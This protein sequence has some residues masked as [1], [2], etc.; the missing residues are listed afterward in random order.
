M[1]RKHLNWTRKQKKK[2]KKKKKEKEKEKE[3]E[4]KKRNS[5][6]AQWCEGQPYLIRIRFVHGASPVST[7][8]ICDWNR[9]KQFR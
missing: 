8:M 7:V 4:K 6:M 2:K 5:N 9:S 1:G 3:K